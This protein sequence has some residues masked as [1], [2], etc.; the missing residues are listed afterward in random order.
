LVTGPNNFSRAGTLVKV[1]GNRNGSP[2]TAIYKITPPGGAWRAANNG[3]YSVSLQANEVADTVSHPVASGLLGTFVVDTVAPTAALTAPNVTANGGET[4]TFTVTY[5]DNLGL[6]VAT[7][8]NSD[9][10]VTGPR[11][12]RQLAALVSVD[13]NTD[14]TP[15][16]ATYQI[17][18]KGGAWS[19]A[20]NGVFTVSIQPKQVKDVGGNS[21]ASGKLGTFTVNVPAAGANGPLAKGPSALTAARSSRATALAAGADA[22]LLPALSQLKTA[23]LRTVFASVEDW[24]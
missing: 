21:V 8:D 18:P 3:V 19:A 20:N 5:T 17:T 7:L 4:Y 10:K 15:R 22:A 24:L 14:G 12:Y 13:V 6:S 2:R 16:T 23:T 11:G 9:V 1:N